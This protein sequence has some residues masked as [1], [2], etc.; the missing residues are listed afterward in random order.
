VNAVLM[1]CAGSRLPGLE[2]NIMSLTKFIAATCTVDALDL[3][4]LAQESGETATDMQDAD[5]AA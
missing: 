1:G 5:T 4:V 2:E 3:P